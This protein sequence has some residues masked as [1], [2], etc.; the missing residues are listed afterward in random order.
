MLLNALAMGYSFVEV[1]LI[2]QERAYGQSKAARLSNIINAEQTI[3]RL[4]WNL[5]VRNAVAPRPAS[6][7][8]SLAEE[9]R[10]AF[11]V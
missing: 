11:D 7:A 3:L 6:L 1:P 4:W 8:V 5:R 10:P 2:H 9:R